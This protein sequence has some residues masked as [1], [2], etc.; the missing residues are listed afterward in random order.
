MSIRQ[1]AR[2]L[3]RSR[4]QVE[5]LEK[6][7]AAAPHSEQ[8]EIEEIRERLR[9]ARAEMQQLENIMAGAK[10]PPPAGITSSTFKG[11]K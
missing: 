5:K 4:Q 7:L 3:Y 6:E 1:I 8:E 11:G 2:E 10:T 9:G